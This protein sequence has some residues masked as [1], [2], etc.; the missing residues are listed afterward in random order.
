M[1]I[2]EEAEAKVLQ[3]KRQYSVTGMSQLNAGGFQ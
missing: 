1:M 2:M 3:S